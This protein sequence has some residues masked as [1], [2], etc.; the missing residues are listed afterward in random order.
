MSRQHKVTPSLNP[1]DAPP[2]PEES[3]DVEISPKLEDVIPTA[4]PVGEKMHP[5]H[6]MATRAGF[7][8]L[9]RKVEGDKFTIDGIHHLGKWMKPI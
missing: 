7:Y 2:A 9:E 3:A 1:Q 6:V 4:P 5:I 8:K